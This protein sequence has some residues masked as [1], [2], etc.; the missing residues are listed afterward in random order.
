MSLNNINLLQNAVSAIISIQEISVTSSVNDSSSDLH[1]CFQLLK[2]FSQY[3]QHKLVAY[4]LHI[5]ESFEGQKNSLPESES[6]QKESN[7]N[8]TELLDNAA[9]LKESVQDEQL[10]NNEEKSSN[11][12]EQDIYEDG[13][14]L[15]S[16]TAANEKQPN[17][18]FDQFKATS[19][20][21]YTF[22]HQDIQK[23][24]DLFMLRLKDFDGEDK[25]RIQWKCKECNFTS[26]GKMILMDHVVK[27]HVNSKYSCTE[28]ESETET[29]GGLVKHSLRKHGKKLM[30]KNP[31][32]SESKHMPWDDYWAMRRANRNKL[33]DDCGQEFIISNRKSRH[34]YLRHVDNHKIDKASCKCDIEFKFRKEKDS[35][36]KVVHQGYFGCDKCLEFF[37]AEN[38][39]LIHKQTHESV[40]C[41][42]CEITCNGSKALH[43]HMLRAHDQKE[44]VCDVCS[45]VMRNYVLLMEHKRSK[46]NSKDKMCKICFKSVSHMRSHIVT[47]HTKEEDKPFFCDKCE[48]GFSSNKQ[49]TNH[50]FSV[51]LKSRPYKCRYNCGADY[52]DPSNMYQHEKRKHGALF[53]N[54]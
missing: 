12:L 33:C 21:E 7:S 28:C 45:K 18:H 49:L 46:H 41:S 31:K 2:H 23:Y 4:D 19:N 39:L 24:V 34:Q 50:Q 14:E 22:V 27:N 5:N 29:Y 1:Q 32:K 10:E 53:S 37:K 36:M 16:Q 8:N 9:G 35:H 38:S 51:H 11:E 42:K 48:K 54:S 17:L 52:N 43:A 13:A 15:R 47:V 30:L 40:N 6:H 44:Y 3:F 20:I 26:K 25:K